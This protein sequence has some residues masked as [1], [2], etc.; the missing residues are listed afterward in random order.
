[1]VDFPFSSRVCRVIVFINGNFREDISLSEV[2]TECNL[3]PFH[4]ER[5]FKDEVGTSIKKFVILRRLDEAARLLRSGKRAGVIQV[6]LDVGFGDLSNF[7]RQ[8]R[9][10]IGCPPLAYRNCSRDPR[11]CE[12][13]RNSH[14]NSLGSKKHRIWKALAADLSGLCYINRA[15]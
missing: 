13:K 3:S 4:L 1:M 6:S 7:I 8:F 14:I 5:L 9:K 15:I 11:T 12:L 10:Y 2:A